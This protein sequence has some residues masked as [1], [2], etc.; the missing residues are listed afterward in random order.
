[1][2]SC[3]DYVEKFDALRGK[4]EKKSKNRTTIENAK[5]PKRRHSA[6]NR[7]MYDAGT[8]EMATFICRQCVCC[9]V[10]LIEGNETVRTLVWMEYILH[11]QQ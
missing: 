10:V 2:S 9:I 7:H 8:N 6:C 11:L 1:M 4:N 5:I 3:H